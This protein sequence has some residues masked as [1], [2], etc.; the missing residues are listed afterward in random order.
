MLFTHPGKV[1]NEYINGKTR[2]YYN[3][4]KYIIIIAGIYA[5]LT[6]YLNIL[7]ANMNQMNIFKK[8]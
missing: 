8:M 1:V 6:I 3:P 4:L 5:F 7:D 2:L